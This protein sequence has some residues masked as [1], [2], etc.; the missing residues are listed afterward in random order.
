MAVREL[1]DEFIQFDKNI[2]KAVTRLPGGLD[3]TSAAFAEMGQIA[4]REA[5][6]TEFSAGQT[7]GAIEQLALAGF[8]LEQSMA[9]LPGTINLATNANVAVEEA[10]TIAAKSL[11]AFG[12]KVNDTAQLTA[13]LTRVNDVFST[14][15]SNAT[16]D[17]T[18]LFETLK[19]GGPAAHAAGQ[20]I[21]TFSAVT[22]VLADSAIDAS[23]AGT[24][25]RRAF[26]NLAA[27]VPKAR[28][29]LKKLGISIKDEGTG[30]FRDF[31]AIMK[32]V[33]TATKDMTNV[34]RL[35]SLS[36]I[37]GARAVNA[38][39]A[40]L[41]RGVDN[42]KDFRKNLE[43]AGGASKKMANT[44]RQS[45]GNRLLILRSAL[46]ELGF[47]FLEA[48]AGKAGEGVEGAI[49]AVQQFDVKPVVE[50]V[51]EVIRFG[52]ELIDVVKPFLRWLPELIELWIAYKIAMQAVAAVE[53]VV[54]FIKLAAA[55]KGAS[56]AM[57]VFS[58]I[59]AANPIGLIII[60]VAALIFVLIQLVKHWDDVSLAAQNF[61]GDVEIGFIR[62][63]ITVLKIIQTMVNGVL[64]AIS[65]LPKALGVILGI[66][67][68]ALD[69]P[70]LEFDFSDELAQMK[71]IRRL[72]KDAVRDAAGH[73]VG[74]GMAGMR[75]GG[76]R[77]TGAAPAPVTDAAGAFERQL[78][79][80]LT[81]PTDQTVF[82]P[83]QA[84]AQIARQNEAAAKNAVDLLLGQGGLDAPNQ[85]EAE[86]RIAFE[87]RITFENAPENMSFETETT[88]APPIETAGLGGQ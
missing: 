13:N 12:L 78:A 5:A 54:F 55:I 45:L 52:K 84:A 74:R 61:I 25:L 87:G 57:A 83:A 4:R 19:F 88:G 40:I 85:A 14:T 73:G 44:I 64:E 6:R 24:S 20:S 2:T 79:A 60:G 53:A 58:A 69:L 8:N 36:T 86:A 42:V 11:G 3:R 16:L 48:F 82:G 67:I 33:E 15:V 70:R 22:G 65:A 28:K 76:L 35:S 72:Q 62:M 80:D 27:P 38:M 7:A 81:L 18:G 50:G 66:D 37:F 21:E 10:T 39:N 26:L 31:L 46:I 30:E 9:A 75:G 68:D 41:V 1:G 71:E 47:K 23:I 29:E 77:R 51:K 32:D 43:Q 56:G 63:K 59:A 17:I 49:K 34:Q